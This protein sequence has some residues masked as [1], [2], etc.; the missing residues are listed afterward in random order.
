[1]LKRI[2]PLM[3]PMVAILFTG[4]ATAK[5]LPA[6]PAS[7]DPSL[8]RREIQPPLPEQRSPECVLPQIEQLSPGYN[9]ETKQVKPSLKAAQ[10]QF[11]LRYNGDRHLKMLPLLPCP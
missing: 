6:I 4:N 5:P 3:L 2:I 8:I 1:M 9:R 11:L 10:A 7:A